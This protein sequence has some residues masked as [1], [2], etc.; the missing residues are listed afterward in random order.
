M[1]VLLV[2]IFESLFWICIAIISLP[3]V[4]FAI[5]FLTLIVC[6]KFITNI[7]MPRPPKITKDNFKMH[8][9]YKKFKLT[10]I[11]NE[12]PRTKQA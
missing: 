4:V 9:D 10:Q 8:P 2:M 7:F 5:P 11:K 12:L 3:A 6:V 1:K